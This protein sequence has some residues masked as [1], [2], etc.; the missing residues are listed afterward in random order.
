LAFR[1]RKFKKLSQESDNIYLN[2]EELNEI[3]SLDLSENP[4]LERTR[5]LFIVGCWTGLRFSD[6]TAIKKVN[7]KGEFIHIRTSKTKEKVVIPI[8]WTIKEIMNKYEGIYDNS[9]PPA[10]SN[11]KMNKY[12]KE[13]GEL[14]T[15]KLHTIETQTI[16][17]GGIERTKSCKKFELISTHTARRSMATNLYEQ[18]VPTLTIMQITGHKTEKAFLKYI[19][20]SKEKHAKIL[21]AHWQEARHLKAV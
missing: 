4:R 10:I 6:F 17:K 13:V 21:Q 7:I 5:D 11:A 9:L 12:I 8:H 19:K 3:Y 16:T 1:S 18:L 2:E 15:S 20:T 14:C